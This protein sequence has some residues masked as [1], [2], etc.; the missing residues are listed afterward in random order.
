MDCELV[1]VEGNISSSTKMV[2]AA[3]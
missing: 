3:R 2:F 1:A